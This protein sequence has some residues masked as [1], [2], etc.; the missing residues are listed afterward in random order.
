M[1]DKRAQ[2][3]RGENYMTPK[4]TTDKTRDVAVAHVDDL[5]RSKLI[6]VRDAAMELSAI[7][8][9]A[10]PD[11]VAADPLWRFAQHV[12]EQAEALLPKVHESGIVEQIPDR[13]RE[14]VDELENSLYARCESCCKG[15]LHDE[16]HC[17]APTT[18][19]LLVASGRIA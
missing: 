4:M 5:L 11:S 12:I 8:E 10:K 13:E 1:N 9:F 14:M 18:R 15:L 16:A 7:M 3:R 6:D 2:A 17:G 19:R